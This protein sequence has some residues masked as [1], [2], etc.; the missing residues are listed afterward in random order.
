MENFPPLR[1]CFERFCINKYPVLPLPGKLNFRLR[2]GLS[3]I[4]ISGR[5]NQPEFATGPV[6]FSEKKLLKTIR[7]PSKIE[8]PMPATP[9]T[10]KVKAR[11]DKPDKNE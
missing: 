3:K 8:V 4:G 2:G 11:N 1:L 6:P 10:P 7:S 5:G 9:E